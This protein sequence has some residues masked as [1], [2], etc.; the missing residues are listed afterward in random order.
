MKLSNRNLGLVV[1]LI[2]LI[3]VY[4]CDILSPKEK[5][6]ATPVTSPAITPTPNKDIPHTAS[7]TTTATETLPAKTLAKVGD[8]S[9]TLD[10]FNERVQAL[11]KVLKDFD[12]KAP[13]AKEMVLQELIRQQLL[14]YEAKQEKIDQLKEV[15]AA[16]SDFENTMMVQEY[17]NRLVQDMHVSQ[18]EAKDYY[19]ANP[20]Q[21]VMPVEKQLREIVV[22]TESEA[23]DILVRILQNA[24]FAQMAKERSKGK[25]AAEGG[26]L[27]FLMQ[28]P[29]PQMQ[30]E[31]ESLNKG[32]V[33]RVFNGPD[34]FYIVKV[35]NIRGGEKKSF[36]EVKEQLAKWLLL[37]KQ[38]DAVL[39]KIGEIAN[40]VK[41]QVN[42]DLLKE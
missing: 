42:A 41:V 31:I 21:F 27:G 25:S 26:D 17:A 5:K 18:Q 22:S 39:Q 6:A 1:I 15:K 29:F 12:E 10:E 20:D 14:V 11:K 34:G 36:D 24:D 37:K 19:A 3:A 28:A 7:D 2:S 32:E 40:K 33:S 9:I 30:K 16:V 23:K 8:W 38:Q 13:G 35:E 4:G